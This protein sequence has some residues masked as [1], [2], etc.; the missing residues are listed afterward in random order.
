M[1]H[2]TSA[3]LRETIDK[4]KPMVGPII[5]RRTKFQVLH[6]ALMH[7]LEVKYIET[8]SHEEVSLVCR[9]NITNALSTWYTN[10]QSK[11]RSRHAPNNLRKRKKRSCSPWRKKR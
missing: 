5:H 3:G 7:E 10:R 11:R 4:L 6:E 2:S 1:F 9:S 8:L